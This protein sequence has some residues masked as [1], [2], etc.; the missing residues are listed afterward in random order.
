M[1]KHN[2][3]KGLT[4][5]IELMVSDGKL[6]IYWDGHNK[7]LVEPYVS[8]SEWKDMPPMVT[9]RVAVTTSRGNG[10]SDMIIANL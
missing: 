5:K 9:L 7:A 1:H 3:D 6:Y 2:E 4:Q 10:N 8:V